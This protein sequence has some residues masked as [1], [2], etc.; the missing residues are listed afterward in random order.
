MLERAVNLRGVVGERLPTFV[1]CAY[2]A[3][4]H[5]PPMHY[6]VILRTEFEKRVVGV[7]LVCLEFGHEALYGRCIAR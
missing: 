7:G 5:C 6:I 4:H 1:C 3:F 2:Y